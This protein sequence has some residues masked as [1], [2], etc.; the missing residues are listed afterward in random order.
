MTINVTPTN[1]CPV[2]QN[3]ISDLTAM[4]DDPDDIIDFS[5]VFNDPE[6]AML[7]Y[8]VSNTNTVLLSATISGTNIIVDYV[9]DE[10]GTAT[11]TLTAND[12]G[13]GSTVDE[14]FMI[15]VVHKTIHQWV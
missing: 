3:N 6:G 1:D 11:I 5:N 4:E 12:S 7:T 10:T 13:C 8:T 2:V 15:T 9:D 14:T